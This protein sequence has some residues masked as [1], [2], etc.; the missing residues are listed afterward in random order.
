[1]LSVDYQSNMP[2]LIQNI[3]LSMVGTNMGALRLGR[4]QLVLNGFR[5][6]TLRFLESR[7]FLEAADEISSC[8]IE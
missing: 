4:V 5:I 6:R 1:M 3:H 8:I 7:S 2:Y